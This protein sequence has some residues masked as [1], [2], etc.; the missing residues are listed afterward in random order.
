MDK[1]NSIGG[2]ELIALEVAQPIERCSPAMGNQY[3]AVMTGTRQ[4]KALGAVRSDI[5]WNSGTLYAALEWRAK[6]LYEAKTCMD[7]L[8]HPFTAVGRGDAVS[9]STSAEAAIRP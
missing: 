7:A 6:V 3:M 4:F 2:Y 5:D 9:S 1:G 8:P